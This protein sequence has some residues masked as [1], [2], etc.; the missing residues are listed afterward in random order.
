MDI[1]IE[2]MTLRDLENIKEI[3][4]IEFD[5]F[6]NYNILKEELNSSNSYYIVAKSEN[7]LENEIVGFAGMKVV[8]DQ[9]DIMNIVTKKAYRNQGIGT[10]LLK[11]LIL[12]SKNLQLSSISLEVNEENKAAIYLYKKFGFQQTGFRK[13]YYQNKNGRIMTLLL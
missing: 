10:I 7:E 3:L 6:W 11:N 9:S 2:K 1:K 12:L 13:N 5:D 8:I 4:T